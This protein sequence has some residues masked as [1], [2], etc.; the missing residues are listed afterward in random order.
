[1]KEYNSFT[2]AL[3]G[4]IGY[5]TSVKI[6]KDLHAHAKLAAIGV[7]VD[8]RD[9]GGVWFT[10]DRQGIP[11]KLRELRSLLKGDVNS[12][13][14]AV[15]IT[16]QVETL[17]TKPS[18]DISV[19]TDPFKGDRQ[20]VAIWSLW[21]EQ[22]AHAIW[23]KK[24][25]KPTETRYHTSTSA[26]PNAGASVIS[27]G[28]DTLAF[29]QSTWAMDLLNRCTSVMNR[30]EVWD[31]FCK[32][33]MFYHNKQTEGVIKPSKRT[34]DGSYVLARLLHLPDKAGKTRTV[35]C[36]TWWFQEILNPFHNELYGLL[37]TIK[38][39]GTASH[40]EA[41][42]T[43]KL[44]TCQGLKLWSFDL[45]AATDRFP[46]ALQHAVVAGLKGKVFADTWRDVMCIPAYHDRSKGMVNW[47]VGQPMGAKTSWAVFALTHHTV[48]RQ[49][50]R[51]HRV[52][53]Q[54]YVIIGDDIVINNEAV[55]NSY[56]SLL[57]DFGVDYSPKKTIVPDKGNGGSVAEFAKRIFRDG[58]EYSPLTASLLQVTYK[59]RSYAT[60]VNVLQELDAKWGIG[61]DLYKDHLLFL[62]PAW[63]LFQ[64]LPNNWKNNLAV[65]LGPGLEECAPHESEA[66]NT[67]IKYG[68]QVD[69]P[70]KEIDNL[71]FLNALGQQVTERLSKLLPD[72]MLIKEKFGEERPE[73][74][75]VVGNFL[76]VPGHPIHGVLAR[77]EE[78]ILQCC[79]GVA[80]GDICLQMF[81]DIGLDI[82]YLKELAV[83][84]TAWSA[85]KRLMQRRA[86]TI[87][88][89]WKATY[90][91]ALNPEV[92]EYWS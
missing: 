10:I 61:A 55:A 64:L 46:M 57:N 18:S 33:V 26:G 67:L 52:R 13:R 85:Y 90:H 23:K 28:V 75:W 87:L 73:E 63:E 36:L 83:H 43:V 21:C 82:G 78:V 5:N 51:F 77:L 74:E 6:L 89:F 34:H 20:E 9:L 48:L 56:A 54:A 91:G 22:Y 50:C 65:T 42:K 44:W 80:N 71:T 40:G 8:S 31:D 53:G 19:I 39:D 11:R 47:S 1:M 16:S 69:N 25:T 27:A 66:A 68:G 45:T 7:D 70:W 72:L 58:V 17:R 62:P 37:K 35:Y 38:E 88:T 84:G 76:A 3:I 59:D 24:T 4:T 49:L 29:C 14:I 30:P 86:N 60:F 32:C 92:D 41:S 79:R 12:K 2:T 15:S 81:T